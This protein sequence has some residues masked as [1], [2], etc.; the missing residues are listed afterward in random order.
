MKRLRC[1]V[2]GKIIKKDEPK[3][4]KHVICPKTANVIT[5]YM[6]VGCKK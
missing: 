3:A 1:E 5:I 2:C 4:Y 6:H